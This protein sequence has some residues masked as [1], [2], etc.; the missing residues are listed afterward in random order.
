MKFGNL[1]YLKNT[2][3]HKFKTKR[4]IS[5]HTR[6]MLLHHL[7]QNNVNN[8]QRIPTN[9]SE[10]TIRDL[11]HHFYQKNKLEKILMIGSEIYSRFFTPRT[12]HD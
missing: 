9:L 10:S 1:R 8:F 6:C 3:Y 7:V 4:L 2:L 11:K 12:Y 5:R